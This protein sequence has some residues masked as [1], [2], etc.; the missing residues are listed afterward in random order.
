MAFVPTMRASRPGLLSAFVAIASSIGWAAG[1]GAADPDYFVGAA[2]VDVTPDYPTRLNGFASRKSESVGVIQHI[3]A[4]ALA[5]SQEADDPIV[6]V[7]L[8]NLGVRLPMVDEVA[9]R[10]SAKTGL[11]RERL[12]LTFT[13]THSAPKVN[14]ASDNIFAEPIPA[15]HQAHLDR[16]TAELTDALEKVVLEAIANRKPATLEWAVGEVR[17]AKNRRTVGGPVD[18]SLPVLVAKNADGKVV[19][20]YTS[21]ACHCVTLSDNQVSGDWAGYAAVGINRHFPD[22]VAFVSIGCGSDQNPV[23]GVTGDKTEVAEQQGFEIADEVA[24]LVSTS[25]TRIRGPVTASLNRIPLAF[26]D[27]PTREQYQELEKKGGAAGYNATTQLARLDRGETLPTSLEY[28]VQ[29]CSFGE[30]LCMVFLGGEVC[31]DYSLRLKRELASDRLWPHGYSND[32]GAYIPSERLVKEGGYGGGA[33]TP[34]FALPT[35]LKAG[36]EQQIL[37]EVH[38]QVPA[39][40]Q[41]PPGTDG[42]PP[43][44]PADAVSTLTTHPELRVELVAAE[45]L[46]ADP[47]AIDFGLDGSVWVA[48]MNDYARGVE[49]EFEPSGQIRVLTDPDRNGTYDRSTV[50]LGGLRYPTDVKVWRNGALVC[51]APDILYAEDTNGDGKA[52]VRRVLFTG[53][54][55]QN[56]QARVNSLQWGLDN[57]IYAS[58]GLF[59]GVITNEM[60]QTFDLTGR[61][62]RM[63]PDSG[64]M[65]PV[66]G[67]TQQSRVRDDWGNWFGCDNGTLI[68][69]Y[70][71]EDQYA[72]RNPFVAPPAT[73]VFV[74]TG[75]DAGKL[76]PSGDLVLFRLSGPAGAATAACGVGIYRDNLLGDSYAGNSFSCEPVNQLI[77]RQI[78]MREGAIFRGHRADNEQH[79]EFLTSTDRWFRPVQVRTGP[80]GGVWI[81][82]MYR[83]VIEHPRWI[84]DETLAGLNVFAGQGMGRLYRVLPDGDESQPVEDLSKLTNVELASAIDRVNGTQRDQIHQSLIWR[85]AL[86]AANELRRVASESQIAPARL[87]ALCALD[88]LGQLH[89]EPL[90]R[91]LR[92]PNSE[93]R[94]HAIRLSEPFFA[95]SPEI[96]AAV[97]DLK[98]DSAF[99]VQLQLAQSLGHC[100]AKGASA[101]LAELVAT[102]RDRYLISAALSSLNAENLAPVIERV[103][104]EPKSRRQVG[105][106]VLATAA[107]LAT[108]DNISALL[109]TLLRRDNGWEAW[110]FESTSQL[111]DGI[112]RRGSDFATFQDGPLRSEVREL[113]TAARRIVGESAAAEDLVLAAMLLL[114]RPSGSATTQL[115]GPTDPHDSSRLAEVI[116]LQR[117][118][119]V[120]M[121]AVQAIAKRGDLTGGTA[122][123]ERLPSATPTVRREIID[124]LLRQK[125]WLKTSLSAIESGTIRPG[126]LDAGARERLLAGADE[127]VRE[128]I[129]RLL[130]VTPDT[131]RRRLVDEWRDVQTLPTDS[132][133]GRDVF[134]KRCAGCH[135][136]Q[137][138]GHAVGPDLAALTTRSVNFLLTAV[139]DPNRDVDG[140]YQGYVAMTDDGR[141]YNGLL[142]S[143]TASSL[144]LREAESKDHVLLRNRIEELRATG[145]SAMPEGFEKDITPQEMANLF[146]FLQESGPQPKS[147][148]GNQP[149]LVTKD[150][151]GE[152]LLSASDA[153]IFG[154]D[155]AFESDSPFRNIG[156]WHGLND[157]VSW[158]L[159]TDQDATFDIW[160]DYSC[161]NST[162]GNLLRIEGGDP[163]IRFA[164]RGTGGWNHY[165]QLRVGTVRLPAGRNSITLRPH[166]SLRGPAFL[167]LRAVCL[168][169]AGAT[170][171]FARAPS[172]S[173]PVTDAAAIAAKILDDSRSQEEREK[174][175][176]DSAALSAAI[177]T[178]M[179]ADLPEGN[180]EE[181]YRRIPWIWRVAIAAGKRNQSGEVL[182]IV[183][184]SLPAVGTP[185]RDW[186]SVVIG[187]GIINGISLVGAWPRDRLDRLIA[188]NA[189][190]SARWSHTIQEASR[191]ADNPAVRTGTRYDA[192]RIIAM[193]TWELHGQQLAGYLAKGVDDELQ[194]GAISGLSDMPAADAGRLLLEN[195]A[196]YSEQNQSMALDAML[197]T[198]PRAHRLLNA[199]ESGAVTATQLGDKRSAT[200]RSH[201]DAPLRTRAVMLLGP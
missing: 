49:E 56:G 59:G 106:Q 119:S 124:A 165:R 155:I 34:Y 68:R 71:V 47:V 12:A 20:I 114:G 97:L 6:I 120:Q 153:A 162:A 57:W 64:V 42:V 130:D 188:G 178:A 61:D 123:V 121:A 91:A 27:I 51:D 191:M 183:D 157:M 189:P 31:V 80:D 75:P 144:T 7:T 90:L 22:A 16:Y 176:A 72:R 179:V 164:V 95:S 146:A 41:V 190:L 116:S 13:H 137:T 10:V 186:Q 115:A 25:M 117:A 4:K 78:L 55:T 158:T 88:G 127:A 23:S 5:V 44:A 140:R 136:L 46:I 36:I 139:L 35:T 172:E 66:T 175:I 197:R 48:Q 2:A 58:C 113:F 24:R 17:F 39:P 181:E 62:F 145:R 135:K 159:Q 29:V 148:P 18:H 14:G 45:P 193:E 11:K 111:L 86:D 102:A 76:Y 201:S 89:K 101:V 93:V 87:S 52:D 200:L 110:Q 99:E 160:L 180:E 73:S 43:T 131:D 53:F 105:S 132:Q 194:M 147:F 1:P 77:Y 60:G 108:A 134:G 171:R 152:W 151:H 63:N 37:D 26:N 9:R 98:N 170:P 128:R 69:H 19:A 94:R 92:D 32:F 122:L 187:G 149:H 3:W 21:Y 100:P 85:Q 168:V 54:I 70:P 141:T 150:E 103:L 143:E 166:E 82:D 33:E 133:A 83:Y 112:D 182:A 126:D 156:Y 142:I 118:A 125:A 154:G 161:E 40:F 199:I 167:D 196:N 163:T 169:T 28:P 38:R 109:G 8:D 173:K 174:L 65:E 184:V 195:F 15:E 74:P 138:V 198:V 50:F 96:V 30:D 79:S 104:S 185:L 129:A 107:G 192:L 67:R 177:I 81:V 84:P